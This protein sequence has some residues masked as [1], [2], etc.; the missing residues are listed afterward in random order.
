MA[1]TLTQRGESNTVKE[2]INDVI[3]EL[4]GD[5]LVV[6]SKLKRKRPV[7]LKETMFVVIPRPL[8]LLGKRMEPLPHYAG[9]V[10]CY[11]DACV[12]SICCYYIG[13]AVSGMLHAS[14][15]LAYR[16]ATHIP[17]RYL[18][19]TLF[20]REGNHRTVWRFVS[21]VVETQTKASGRTQRDHV[22]R[23][24]GPCLCW[25]NG[26]NLSPM[27]RRRCGVIGMHVSAP[28]VATIGMTVSG[29][30][31]AS[32]VHASA[33]RA[34]RQAMHSFI[35]VIYRVQDALFVREGHRI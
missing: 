8:S 11:R 12:C 6:L 33:P 35:P 22:C 3:T 15:P 27:T 21:R 14:A 24:H 26:G 5:L 23:D 32:M 20:V 18:Q 13:M 31:H 28:F 10:W 7:E 29:I 16:Q 1:D 30:V 19:D 9:E 17:A 34:Y 25:E 2:T 4:F